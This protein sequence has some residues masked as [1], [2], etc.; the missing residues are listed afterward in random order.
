MRIV[1]KYLPG[2]SQIMENKM[3]HIRY[4]PTFLKKKMLVIECQPCLILCI[5]EIHIV[6]II[7]SYLQ[8]QLRKFTFASFVSKYLVL[9]KQLMTRIMVWCA[10]GVGGGGGY[11]RLNCGEVD[12][13]VNGMM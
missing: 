12:T 8:F 3:R 1:M 5:N 11:G 13:A 10:A 4:L 7:L 2:I 6:S 9:I